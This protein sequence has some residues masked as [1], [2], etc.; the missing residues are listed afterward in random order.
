M[1][2]TEQKYRKTRGVLLERS[3]PIV[4]LPKDDPTG[5]LERVI[6][7]VKP[8]FWSHAQVAVPKDKLN[9]EELGFKETRMAIPLPGEKWFTPSYRRG[10]LHAHEADQYYL[11]HK[12]S[13]APGSVLSGLKHLFGDVPKALQLSLSGKVEPFVKKLKK[14]S[15]SHAY[16]MAPGADAP[17]GM[18]AGDFANIQVKAQQFKNF[19][20][21]QPGWGT[22]MWKESMGAMLDELAKLGTVSDEEAREAL[23]RYENLEQGAPSKK[24]IARYATIGAVAGP[25]I[26]AV[27]KLIQGGRAPGQSLLH[28]LS[29]AK[30]NTVGG[31][32][33]GFASDAAKGAI[34][35]GAIPLIRGHVDRKAE[36]KTLRSYMAERTPPHPEHHADATGTLLSPFEPAAE[37]K[38][39][40][41]KLSSPRKEKD[42]GA[43]GVTPARAWDGNAMPLAAFGDEE[44]SA[45]IVGAAAGVASAHPVLTGALGG[46]LVSKNRTLGAMGG[47]LTGYGVNKGL[48]VSGLKQPEGEKQAAGAPTRGGFLMSS[49]MPSMAPPPT[50]IPKRPTGGTNFAGQKVNAMMKESRATTP[51]GILRSSR[52]V[53]GPKVT[54]PSGP[55]LASQTGRPGGPGGFKGTIGK[56]K[57]PKMTPT[58]PEVGAQSM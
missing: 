6:D 49:E 50:Y 29:G 42:S 23:N 44:K 26:G 58:M 1:S 51:A 20:G 5:H 55:N 46:A 18:S 47:A 15:A 13:V 36:M 22:P 7:D 19:K 53:A 33:R 4:K 28:H 14:T 39:G 9:L 40:V 31:I 21:M 57:G 56:Y 35:S 11:I 2:D 17:T 48:E 8:S 32:A 52:Q 45:G 34:G 43:T 27:G 16:L 24:Q 37:S 54:P 10:E 3:I 30:S 25:T 12:D 38:G 41:S